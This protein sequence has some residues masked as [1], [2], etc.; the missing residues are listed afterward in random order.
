MSATAL[1]TDLAR[2]LRSRGFTG[3]LIDREHGSY[4]AS[5][6]VWNGS[7]DRRPLAIARSCDTEDVAA[8]VTAGVA[9]GLRLAVRGGGHSVAGH[10]TCDD[11]LVVD[12]SPMRRVSVDPESRLARVA[13]GALLGDL[14]KAT[15][16]HGLA[17][18]AGQVSH[19]GVAGLTLGGGVGYLMRRYGLTIDSLR[20]AQVVTADG[21]TVRASA[22]ENEDLFWALRGGG[23]NF[24]VVTEF[25]F[26][27]HEVGPIINAGVL[28]YPYERATEVL[29]ASRAVM[30]CAP[31][32]LSIHEILIRVPSH[33]PFPVELQGQLGVILTVVH[34]GDERRAKADIA[35]LRR[36][37]P[38][39][40][41]VGPMPY[42]ALQSM[43]DH[44]NRAGLGHYSK[45]HWLSGYED[46][47][48]DTLVDALA[49]S[50]SP[51][52]HLITAR[53]GGAIERVPPG[54]TAFAHRSAANL[55]W[56]IDLWDD[57]R[58]DANAHRQWVNDILEA[59]RPFSTGG[60]YVNAIQADE[61]PGRVRNAYGEDTFARLS[62]VK[63][64]WDPDN[65]FRLN[66]NVPPLE[67]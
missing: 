62:G 43:I 42:L 21:D 44:D 63:R 32:E 55:L 51:L 18:P 52:A 9:L 1:H 5:R 39:F 53:M 13:G 64:R 19:T 54:A 35:P 36:I 60:G 33:E 23:G 31:E 28:V 7:I 56:I 61:G 46:R 20:S 17:V 49:Q 29:R 22:S 10:S 50:P 40:D 59:T 30:A 12:L 15:Q 8:A 25:E 27:L 41:L 2:D 24:G 14:D 37:G 34:I 45:S 38:A 3:Q 16:Q 6:R 11:G 66:A 48:I 67:D 57:P 65:V 47:L 26:A 4:E 58:S